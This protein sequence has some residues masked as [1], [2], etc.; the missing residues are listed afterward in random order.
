[1]VCP[2]CI[3]AVTE[4]C[5]QFELEILEIQL[6]SVE[7]L[8]PDN[9]NE[10]ALVETFRNRGFDLVVSKDEIL[11]EKTKAA[12]VKLVHVMEETP[13]LTNSSWLEE[14]LNE[15][16]QKISKTFSKL[17]GTTIEKY[18]ISHKIERTKE[19][20]QY[21]ELSFEEIAMKL[22]YKSLSHL[23]KQFKEVEN[24]SLT[25]YKKNHLSDRNSL[26]KL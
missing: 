26:E 5:E 23:S 1:M 19:F 22:G 24:L 11:V 20:I 16:Y 4:V 25:E 15:S 3:E 18:L 21:G 10:K 6:G 7:V 8:V 17:T 13:V 12:I 2:R 9:L 14:E